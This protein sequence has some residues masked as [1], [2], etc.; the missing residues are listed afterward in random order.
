MKLELMNDPRSLYFLT[1][2]Q[3]SNTFIHWP[4]LIAAQAADTLERAHFTAL[5]RIRMRWRRQWTLLL[6]TSVQ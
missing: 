3:N 5:T 6:P 1:I 4:S 2:K